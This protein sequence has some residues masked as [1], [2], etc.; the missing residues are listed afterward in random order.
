MK[1]KIGILT[2]HRSINYGAYLQAFAL[3]RVTQ[4]AVGKDVHV[5]IIDYES[6]KAFNSYYSYKK[7]NPQLYKEFKKA[8]HK[9][10]LSPQYLRTDDLTRVYDF[11]NIQKY[12]CIIVGSDEVWKINGM[13]GFPNAYWLSCDLRNTLKIAYGVSARNEKNSIPIEYIATLEKS[14]KSFNYVG[15]RDNITKQLIIGLGVNKVNINC[16]PVFLYDFGYEAEYRRKLYKK[17]K[18]VKNKRLFVVMI[19]EKRLVQLIKR[20]FGERYNIVS[21]YDINEYA[22]SNLI[23]IDPFEWIK[24]ISSADIVVTNRF[25]GICFSIKYNIPFLALDE[26]D[27]EETSKIHDLLKRYGLEELYCS[28]HGYHSDKRRFSVLERIEEI[29]NKCFC[30][31]EIVETIKRDG[32]S[33]FEYITK[34]E[35]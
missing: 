22:D 32:D 21:V 10:K 26:Y 4:N 27:N 20:H 12:D 3:C 16:D 24:V 25:H 17:R 13:R 19:P 28:Y 18:L 31:D 9:L 14:L 6:E 15:V 2:F 35:M 23:D 29:V 11:L 1:K 34:V 8:L 30:F 5:E 33:Y 7:S